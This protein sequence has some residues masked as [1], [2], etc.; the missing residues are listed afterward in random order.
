LGT[1]LGTARS[2]GTG[3]TA[4][5]HRQVHGVLKIG[6]VADGYATRLTGGRRAAAWLSVCRKLL[7]SHRNLFGICV[8][9]VIIIRTMVIIAVAVIMSGIGVII[10][11]VI[12]IIAIGRIVSGIPPI[13]EGI[14]KEWVIYTE[15]T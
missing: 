14:I 6:V 1:R 11:T 10:P 9:T 2:G 7:P 5:S 3:S 13:P 4:G 12:A 8:P 15:I